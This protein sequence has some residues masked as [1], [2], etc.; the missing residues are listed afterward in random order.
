MVSYKETL[1]VNA[2]IDSVL[3]CIQKYDLH[4]KTSRVWNTH[5]EWKYPDLQNSYFLVSLQAILFHLKDDKSIETSLSDF[6]LEQVKYLSNP[7]P[8]ANQLT[9][10][11]ES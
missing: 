1:E 2:S 5:K 11:K 3:V 6:K 9:S 10:I 8:F 7:D 4:Q